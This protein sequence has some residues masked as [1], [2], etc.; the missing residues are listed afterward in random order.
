M[1]SRIFREALSLES[2]VGHDDVNPMEA[3][4]AL[5][6][7]TIEIEEASHQVEMMGYQQE[8]LEHAHT[9][10]E[11]I[12]VSLESLVSAD[13]RGLDRV[14]AEGYRHAITAI[15]GD[16]LPNPVASLESFGGESECSAATQLSMEGIKDTIKKIW[17]AIKRAVGNAIRAVSD[18]FAKLFKGVDKLEKKSKSLKEEIEKAKKDGHVAK[19]NKFDAPGA[20]RLHMD[21]KFDTKTV[22]DVY[23]NLSEFGNDA[24]VV[25]QQATA[26]YKEL[27]DFYKKASEPA[28][29]EKFAKDA[30]TIIESIKK[31]TKE[32]G[33]VGPGGKTII[34]TSNEDS[35]GAPSLPSVKFTDHPQAK[36]FKGSNEVDVPSLD[37]LQTMN[38]TIMNAVKHLKDAKKNREAVSKAHEDAVKAAESW[39]KDGERGKLSEAWTEVKVRASMKFAQKN[40]NGELA[41]VDNYVFSIARAGVKF[42]EAALKEYA[43]KKDDE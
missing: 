21:G 5:E 19:N 1:S 20:Q 2:N 13:E 18:F 42:A 27:N 30:T 33:Q 43:E 14:A 16:A 9:S 29:A 37:Q 34:I 28:D 7:Q 25:S 31:K 22:L 17:E 12:A 39:V 8:E 11:S 4:L 24:D 35:D 6:S 10:L 38:E 23:S 26:Y 32:V 41:K 15:V 40:L 3:S 36:D